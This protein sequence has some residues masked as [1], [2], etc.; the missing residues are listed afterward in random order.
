MRLSLTELITRCCQHRPR[1]HEWLDNRGVTLETAERFALG[2]DHDGL[3]PYTA[4]RVTVPIYHPWSAQPVSVTSRAILSTADVKWM[5]LP[6][7]SHRLLFGP[8]RRHRLP[9]LAI[10]EGPMDAIALEQA[11]VHAVAAFG[12]RPL[13]DWQLGLLLRWTS[14]FIVWPDNDGAPS[15][16]GRRAAKGRGASL[17]WRRRLLQTGATA[18]IGPY[19]DDPLA[20]DPE[21][22][23]KRRPE[24]VQRVV[25]AVVG[26]I[27]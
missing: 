24:F 18:V 8:V 19:P 23:V 7:P 5:H 14:T 9:Y 27:A 12:V 25:D 3:T 2:Y 22:L 6:F 13:S 20:D 26:G 16:A 4:Q 10:V 1:I 17:A 21:N 11:G 15:A